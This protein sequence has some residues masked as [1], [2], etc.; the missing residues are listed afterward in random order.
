MSALWTARKD[1]CPVVTT[2]VTDARGGRSRRRVV[3]RLRE[4]WRGHTRGTRHALGPPRVAM[5]TPSLFRAALGLTALVT[6]A[7]CL[8]PR[9]AKFTIIVRCSSGMIFH[10]TYLLFAGGSSSSHDLSGL[11]RPR[12][13]IR[14]RAATSTRTAASGLSSARRCRPPMLRMREAGATFG[15]SNGAISAPMQQPSSPS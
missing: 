7:A 5:A 12:S 2:I 6:A 4:L 15:L 9:E 1:G 11:R 3:L 8:A 13:S 14:W 10:G